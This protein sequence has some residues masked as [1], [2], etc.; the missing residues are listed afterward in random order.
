[1]IELADNIVLGKQIGAAGTIDIDLVRLIPSRL[2]VQANSGA[3]KSRTIRRLLEQTHGQVQ[4]IVLDIEG[5]F[6]TLRERYDYIL[7]SKGALLRWRS[8]GTQ[9][10]RLPTWGSTRHHLH[11]HRSPTPAGRLPRLLLKL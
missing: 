8:V 2:L 6:A 4:Q 3:G 1:M 9:G 7:A 5:D 11:G 10:R